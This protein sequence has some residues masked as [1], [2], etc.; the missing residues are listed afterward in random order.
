MW[1]KEQTIFA[2]DVIYYPGVAESIHSTLVLG[3]ADEAWIIFMAHPVCDGIYNSYVNY[4]EGED[5]KNSEEQPDYIVKVK[6]GKAC[7]Q[8]RGG[9]ITYQHEVFAWDTSKS[10]TRY[11]IDSDGRSTKWEE[12]KSIQIGPRIKM[13][14]ACVSKNVGGVKKSDRLLKVHYNDENQI[15]IKSC[16]ACV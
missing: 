9:G 8:P 6:H 16:L 13:V 7:Y 11:F 4:P 5:I 1:R 14:I 15:I 3:H 12:H 10:D 2:N